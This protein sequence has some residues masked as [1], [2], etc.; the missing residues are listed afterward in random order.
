MLNLNLRLGEGIGSAIAY[1]ILESSV[2][3]INEMADFDSAG[4]SKA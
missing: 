2:R 1:P 4:V 3:F